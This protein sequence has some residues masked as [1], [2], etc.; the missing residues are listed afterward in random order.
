M[1]WEKNWFK[2]HQLFSV[3][4]CKQIVQS[5]EDNHDKLILSDKHGAYKLSSY[6]V[7]VDELPKHISKMIFDKVRPVRKM[8]IAKCFIIKYSQDLKPDMGGHYDAT[9]YSMVIN[10]NNDFEGGGTYF[11]LRRYRHNP[12]TNGVGEGLIY[13]A[14]TI[15]SWHE[16]L[17]VTKG[18]RYV[19]NVKFNKRT[20]IGWIWVILK[21][22]FYEYTIV[23]LFS[24]NYE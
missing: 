11:P 2:T 20:F 8:R 23:K 1:K 10:L 6:E 9:R 3:D 24:K 17:P 15:M 12:K 4:E 18:A 21:V 19:L 7:G 16:A 5:V 22:A 14:D 13:K